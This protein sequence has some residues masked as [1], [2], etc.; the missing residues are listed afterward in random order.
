M[1]I[2]LGTAQL[3]LDYGIANRGGLL[4]RT[5]VLA[6]LDCAIEHEVRVLD[7]SPSYGECERRI[8]E[9][10][11]PGAHFS[12]VTKTPPLSGEVDAAQHVESHLRESLRRLAA[13]GVHGLL[14]HRLKPGLCHHP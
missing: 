13:P 11:P 1:K 10:K 6:I 3:G 12:I 5:E 4:S 8:G 2:G 14:V 7:T 9:L